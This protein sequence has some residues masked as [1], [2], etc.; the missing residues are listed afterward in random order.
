MVFLLARP[1][2]HYS[3]QRRG[4]ADVIRVSLSGNEFRISLRPPGPPTG[5][6]HGVDATSQ[7]VWGVAHVCLS[8]LADVPARLSDVCCL[9]KS[10]RI[11]RR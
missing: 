5:C 3:D 1:I 4:R 9:G 7:F 2:A 8:H 6:S 11:G 10:G